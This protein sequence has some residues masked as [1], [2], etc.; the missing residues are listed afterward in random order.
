MLFRAA[1]QV[2]RP[3]QAASAGRRDEIGQQ[4]GRGS[5]S[6]L[7]GPLARGR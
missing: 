1:G 5:F 2:W 3:S 6:P 7:P 4:P